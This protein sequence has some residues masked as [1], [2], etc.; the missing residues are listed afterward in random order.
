MP[1]RLAALA[2]A[3]LVSGGFF[4]IAHVPSMRGLLYVGA[5]LV[6]LTTLTVGIG[7]LR[8]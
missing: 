5:A 8:A 7:L 1:I 2:A 6:V 3:L 4:V